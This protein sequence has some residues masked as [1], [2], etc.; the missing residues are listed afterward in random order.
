[1]SQPKPSDFCIKPT[2]SVLQNIEAEIVAANIMAVLARTEDEWRELSF[3]EYAI[4]RDKD[5]D[6]YAHLEHPY[7]EQVVG[8]TVSPETAALFSP[9]WKDVFKKEC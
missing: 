4:E 6:F 7:F 2:N 5:G 1:M 3:K 9:A 8:Y